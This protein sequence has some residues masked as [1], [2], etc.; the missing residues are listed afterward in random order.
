M[1]RG[2]GRRTRRRG[3]VV[4]TGIALEERQVVALDEIAAVTQRSRS[5]VVRLAI[6]HEIARRREALEAA[7]R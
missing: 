1:A 5:A 3:L 7:A 4:V 6:D 2:M